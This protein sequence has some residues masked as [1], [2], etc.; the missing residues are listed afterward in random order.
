LRRRISN[1]TSGPPSTGTKFLLASAVANEIDT[2]LLMNHQQ[3][4]F[5][6]R[7]V[8]PV[9]LRNPEAAQR[10]LDSK[11]YLSSFF[12]NHYTIFSAAGISIAEATYTLNRQGKDFSF[13]PYFKKTVETQKPVISDPYFSSQAHNHPAIMMTAPIFN[14][15]GALAGLLV[16]SMDLMGDNIL[17][18]IDKI[19]VGKNGFLSLT[20]ADRIMVM[21]PDKTRIMKPIPAGNEL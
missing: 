9:A 15:K 11:S 14:S 18:N 19:R 17:G 5:A 3:L 13:R 6:A 16:G 21:H 7:E 12:D 1:G 20:T 8:P 4:I 2:K 10:F